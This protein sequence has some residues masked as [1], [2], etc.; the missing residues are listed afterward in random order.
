M[1]EPPAI[2]FDVGGPI[3]LGTTTLIEASAGTGKTYTL[4]SLCVRLVAE[5]GVPVDRILVVTFTRAA[6]AELRDR[7]RQRLVEAERHLARR[8]EPPTSAESTGPAPLTDPV[9]HALTH[10]ESGRPCPEEQVEERRSRVARA[11]SDFDSATISTIHGFCAQVRASIG[12]L[13]DHYSD[14]TAPESETELLTQVCADLYF[15]A[16]SRHDHD[17]FAPRGLTQLLDLVTKAR[18]LSGSSVEAASELPADRRAV[19]FVHEALAEIDL[20]LRRQGAPSFDSL[21]TSVRDAIRADGRLV[22]TLRDQFPVA[23]VDE[24]QDTDPVQWEIFRTVFADR[25]PDPDATHPSALFLV[26][27]PK[28]AIYSF[29][30]GDVYTY[31]EARTRSTVR[32]LSTNQRSDPAV[33]AAMNA[34]ADGQRYGDAAIAYQPVEPADRNRHRHASRADGTRLPGLEVR[35]L[36]PVE[37]GIPPVAN[38]VRRAV[39]ADLA[40]VAHQL[41]DGAIHVDRQGRRVVVRPG[42]LAVLVGATSDAR[43]V[44]DA[45][46]RVGIPAVLRLRDDVADSDARDQWRILLHALDRPGSTTRAAAAALTWFF[47]WEPAAVAAAM[48]GADD[49]PAHLDLVALQHQLAQWDRT[50]TA[51]GMAALFGATR[52]ANDLVPRLLATETGERNLTDLEHLAEL[53]HAEARA[54]GRGLTAGSAL[55]IVDGLGGT[56]EDEVAADAAQR[57]IES[58]ADAVQ[59]MTIHGAK[60]LEFPFVLLPTISSGGARVNANRPFTFY[61]PDR[62]GRVIDL[63]SRNDPDTGRARPAKTLTATER[64][65]EA[66][67]RR[68]NCGDQHRLTYVALTRAEHQTVA[69]WTPVGSPKRSGLTRMLLGPPDTEADVEVDVPADGATRLIADRVR[70]RGVHDSVAVTQIDARQPFDLDSLPPLA[71]AGGAL[72]RPDA[73]HE[74]RVGRPLARHGRAWSFTSLAADLHLAVPSHRPGDPTVPLADDTWAH[75]EPPRQD[76]PPGP[77]TTPAADEQG[78]WDDGSPFTGLGGGKD[79]GNLVHHLLEVVDFRDPDPEATFRALLDRPTGQRITAGQRAGLPGALAGVLRTPLGTDLGDLRLADLD[80]THRLNEL[81]FHL[82]LDPRSPV[83]AARIGTLV[84]DHLPVSDPLHRWGRSLAAGLAGLDL[85]GFL[86]GSIDLVLRRTVDG[87]QRFSVIDYKTN[88]LAPGATDPTLRAYRRS[89]TTRAMTQN[90]YVLQA[91][92]YSV[93]LHRYLR[94]RVPG[95]DPTVHLGP[96]GYLFVRAMV[97]PDTPTEALETTGR[98]RAGVYTWSVPPPLVLALDQLFAGSDTGAEAGDVS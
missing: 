91:L 93:A 6:T 96:V 5:H 84:A 82:A 1:S 16:L 57:R 86:T 11:L 31:L 59:I 19:T 88:N 44:A 12:V 48:E 81:G 80:P 54:Q 51:H 35:C 32:A 42:H 39:A 61:D 72:P 78:R 37:G 4:A 17:P 97:G 90:Q 69:W 73:I 98:G 94:W 23:L 75:D 52:R 38:A 26:G 47:G 21:L 7:V 41:L 83:T 40:R 85:E 3:P 8:A 34:L 68:Q 18:M 20:R 67:T 60:G 56:P 76:R 49:D 29:R 33:L 15:A 74:A 36:E 70:D 24:F 89:A 55:A 27:D 50:L 63:S 71:G 2:P 77:T 43:P 10:D 95:Y 30:G 64:D 58:D 28:Q 62:G 92:V 53:I 65:A 79:F 13:A 9:L 46:R 22:Q 14:A 45:L 66:A 25:E 87:V